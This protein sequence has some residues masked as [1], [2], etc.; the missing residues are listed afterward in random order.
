MDELDNYLPMIQL[1]CVDKTMQRLR[2]EDV[3][4]CF[5]ACTASVTSVICMYIKQ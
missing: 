1:I 2:E 3:M 4:G 5:V